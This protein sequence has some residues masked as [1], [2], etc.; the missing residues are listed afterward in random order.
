MSHASPSLKCRECRKV[1]KLSAFLVKNRKGK[2]STCNECH[3]ERV[4][5]LN[6]KAKPKK[7][8]KKS[9]IVVMTKY[10]V[11]KVPIK[12]SRKVYCSKKFNTKYYEYKKQIFD[13]FK[14]KCNGCGEKDPLVL[15]VD[16]VN[17]GGSKQRKR[18]NALDR[19]KHV[20][21]NKDQYQLLCANCNTRKKYLNK[22]L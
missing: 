20:I 21:K 14:N 1:K 13:M 5:I 16:H 17:G 22:E 4:N 18:M 15:Q 11:S 10:A 6:S 2:N 7:R 12:K 19:C 3:Y 9:D 8:R